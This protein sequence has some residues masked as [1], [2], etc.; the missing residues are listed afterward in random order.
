MATKQK[1]EETP[2]D[3][4]NAVHDFAVEALEKVG[5][6]KASLRNPVLA[7]EAN[8]LHQLEM[9]TLALKHLKAVTPARQTDEEE[10]PPSE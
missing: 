9:V 1:T 4:A 2:L 5:E 7:A 3:G 8:A 6:L 10:A